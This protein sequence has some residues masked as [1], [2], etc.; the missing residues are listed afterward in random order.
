MEEREMAK[1]KGQVELDFFEMVGLAEGIIECEMDGE[2]IDDMEP[3]ER[4]GWRAI[5]NGLYREFAKTWGRVGTLAII[6][7]PDIGDDPPLVA[8]RIGK[9]EWLIGGETVTI[10]GL[11]K[12]V[13]ALV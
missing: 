12:N 13:G 10:E 4:K 7:N 2:F 3:G 11:V 6:K 8:L 9:E 1:N 5:R